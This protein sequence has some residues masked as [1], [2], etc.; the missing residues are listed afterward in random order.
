MESACR[1]SVGRVI[2]LEAILAIREAHM[3]MET[4]RVLAQESEI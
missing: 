4:A 1:G 3:Q 2:E